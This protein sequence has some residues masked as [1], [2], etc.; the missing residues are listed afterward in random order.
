[1]PKKLLFQSEILVRAGGS[2]FSW[3]FSRPS[4]Q[5]TVV[6]DYLQ[7]YSG[8][9]GFPPK[10]LFE[11]QKPAADNTHDDGE[12]RKTNIAVL[13]GSFNASGRAYPDVSALADNVPIVALGSEVRML[14]AFFSASEINVHLK[15]SFI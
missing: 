14:P 12:R 8:A 6:N 9:A 5:N 11:M 10:V 15:P 1:M 4:Y 7:K 3:Q 13:K 2:G